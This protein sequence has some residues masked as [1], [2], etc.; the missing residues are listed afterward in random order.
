MPHHLAGRGTG[1]SSRDG[2]DR[3]RRP[4]TTLPPEVH[5]AATPRSGRGVRCCAKEQLDIGVYVAFSAD[6]IVIPALFSEDR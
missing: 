2:L 3:L 5:V 1:D 4:T 6:R